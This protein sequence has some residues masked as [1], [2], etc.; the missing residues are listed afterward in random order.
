MLSGNRGYSAC[1]RNYGDNRFYYYAANATYLL[2]SEESGV[3]PFGPIVIAFS[4]QLCF[5]PAQP[6]VHPLQR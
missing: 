3:Y 1:V 5:R 2:P 4:S 6:Q